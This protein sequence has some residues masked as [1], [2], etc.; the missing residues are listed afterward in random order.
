MANITL[1]MTL[2]GEQAEQFIEMQK[3]SGKDSTSIVKIAL[4]EL[5]KKV[6]EDEDLKQ[7]VK[8]NSLLDV[9]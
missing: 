5:Y 8:I 2:T 6:M 7:K 1:N 9:Q 4:D 3:L